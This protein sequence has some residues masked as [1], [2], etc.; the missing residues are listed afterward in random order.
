MN[1]FT[2]SP[3]LGWFG[4]ALAMAMFALGAAVVAVH[5]RRRA[6]SDETTAACV[7]R[8]LL[9]LTV[10]LML[11]TPSVVTSTDSRA[12]NATDVVVAVDVTGSM[13]VADAHY[14]SDETIGRLDAAKDAVRDITALY[15]DAS[16]MVLRF[17]ATGSVDVPLTPDTHA[18]GTWADTLA[19]EATSVS[20]GSSLDAPLDRLL[21]S[22]KDLRE[23][24]P[25]DAI[26]LYLI[27]DGE[28]TS[29]GERR[30]FST[31]RRYLDDG[32]VIGVGSTEGGRI[33]VVRDGVASDGSDGSDGSSDGG[34][35]ADGDGWV[36]DP[37]TGEP[38]VS[39]MDE[40]TLGAIADEISGTYLHVD[41]ATTMADGRSAEASR[42]WQVTSTVK[43]RERTT[44]V[45]WP[46]A[47]VVLVLA[48][49]EAG[50]WIV[51]SRRLL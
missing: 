36:I 28:Q 46:L 38:G 37:D 19:P 49:W 47:A 7:R 35:Q 29:T 11:L 3:A 43:R 15:P 51:M 4:V 12:V 26:V 44:P 33:P 6:S 18:I 1:G 8:A 2:L 24:R 17:G 21:L 39:R 30:S 31:L 42:R 45:V 40:A 14:G 9:C 27:T 25:D 10:A 34:A 5:V 41:A 20:S 22:L 48:A 32:F 50:A 13:A 16:F 23:E